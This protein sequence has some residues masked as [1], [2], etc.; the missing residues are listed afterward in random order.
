MGQHVRVQD[1]VAVS[2]IKPGPP[3][4]YADFEAP[5]RVARNPVVVIA[6]VEV[7]PYG[8]L[9]EQSAVCCRHTDVI[10]LLSGA[11]DKLP[12]QL[13]KKLPQPGAT[14][15]DKGSGFDPGSILEHYLFEFS[16]AQRSWSGHGLQVCTAFAHERF[17]YRHCAFARFQVAP[18]GIEYD[19]V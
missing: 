11:G 4:V 10:R 1:A 16:G 5:R 2:R 14:S 17:L 13:R 7:N 6:P 12:Q 9:V 18:A 19:M 8:H 15:K 3:S